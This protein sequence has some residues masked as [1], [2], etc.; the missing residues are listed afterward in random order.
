ML[1]HYGYGRHKELQVA[2]F[3][4]RRG[5]DWGRARGSRGPVDL[6]AER[7]KTR[8]AIQVKSTRRDVTSYTRLSL[9]EEMGLIG[10]Q[11][12]GRP[13]RCWRLSPEI[14]FGSFLFQAKT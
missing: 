1:S 5:F 13:S 3:L 7:S 11:P 10:R 12:L 6:L 4:E 2:E 9:S 8:L 14:T